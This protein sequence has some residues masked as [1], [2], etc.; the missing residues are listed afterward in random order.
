[1]NFGET[2]DQLL[3]GQR[4]RRAGWNGK[5]MWVAYSPGSEAL[6]SGAFWAAANRDFAQRNGGFAEVGP[7]LTMK[8]ADGVIEMGWR[9]TSRDM[10][11]HDWE[12]V[13]ESEH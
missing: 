4:M 8:A 1:M 9:P 10:L 2:I 11:A 6:P 5:G 7:C 12:I 13:P 3:L